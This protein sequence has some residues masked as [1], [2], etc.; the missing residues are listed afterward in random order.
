MKMADMSNL[1]VS[2]GTG[3]EKQENVGKKGEKQESQIKNGS[4]FVGKINLNMLADRV[5]QKKEAARKHASKVLLDQFAR[6]NITTDELKE[7]RDKIKEYKA[8]WSALDK[9]KQMYLE[10]QEK[11]KAQYGIQEGSQEQQDLDILRRANK[12]MKSGNIM[13]DGFSKEELERI[14][15]AGANP[16]EYQKRSLQYD[17]II[18]TYDKQ[19]EKLKDG[20]S[21]ETYNII[22]IKNGILKQHGMT[23]AYKASADI[24][25]AAS[26]EIVGMLMADAK[27]HIDEELEKLVEAA[28][29]AAEKKKAEEAKKEEAKAESEEQKEL[30]EEIQEGSAKQDQMQQEIKKIMKDNELT[31][32]DMKGLI[33]NK[34]S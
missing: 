2:F 26:S 3:I 25:E 12:E 10:E 32:E 13:L 5:E 23:D 22:E 30:T 19:I 31:E 33:V 1:N 20:I 11:L 28:K 7:R 24:L 29:E 27:E 6:D 18:S 34:K 15:K 14:Q 4:I 16:T 17:D 8:E 9:E 21:I